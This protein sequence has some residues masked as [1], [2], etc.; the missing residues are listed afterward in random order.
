MPMDVDDGPGQE[1]PSVPE[2][3]S[4]SS[5]PAPDFAAFP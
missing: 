1:Q 5:G 2:P 4:A 3:S